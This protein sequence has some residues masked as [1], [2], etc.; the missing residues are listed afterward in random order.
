LRVGWAFCP[1]PV[2]DVLNRIRG[3]FNVSAVAQAAA[4]AALKDRRH[5]ED[6][7]AHNEEW[8][9]WLTENIRKL[10]LRVDDSVGNFVLIHFL[11]AKGRT[12]LDA[13]AFLLSRGLIL[14]GVVNYGLPDCLRLTIG[15]ADANKAV[16]A[17]LSEFVSSK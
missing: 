10:G 15:T 2:A 6:S 9:G 8:R 16:V 12:A 17:A 14:R 1:A 11:Q 4:V 7:L 3:P 13:D 5:V